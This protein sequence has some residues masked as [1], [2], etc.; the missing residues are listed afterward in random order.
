[1]SSHQVAEH[2]GVYMCRRCS[3]VWDQPVPLSSC[4][5]I[6]SFTCHSVDGPGLHHFGS[7]GHCHACGTVDRG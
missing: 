4:P 7:D 3:M 6:A 1:M 5:G 2:D